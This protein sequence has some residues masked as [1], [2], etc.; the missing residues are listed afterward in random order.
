M[1]HVTQTALGA[2]ASARGRELLR[3]HPKECYPK[4]CQHKFLLWTTGFAVVAGLSTIAGMLMLCRT[5]CWQ[6]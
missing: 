4:E 3:C 1:S 6:H 2:S 5:L